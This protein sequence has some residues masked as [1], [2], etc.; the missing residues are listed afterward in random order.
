MQ[1]P[2]AS[3]YLYSPPAPLEDIQEYFD[4][5]IKY[6]YI[7]IAIFGGTNLLSAPLSFFP[8]Q[9]APFKLDIWKN[10]AKT[11]ADFKKIINFS[12]RLSN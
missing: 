5:F 10:W 6:L 8:A 2:V 11:K 1:P 7:Y 3:R 9:V 12:T 4:N